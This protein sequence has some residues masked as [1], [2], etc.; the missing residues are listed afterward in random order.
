MRGAVGERCKRE[1]KRM[2]GDGGAI[3]TGMQPGVPD[4]VPPTKRE[5]QMGWWAQ[6]QAVVE[7]CN[8]WRLA[9]VVP[10]ALP[11]LGFETPWVSCASFSRLLVKDQIGD[12]DEPSDPVPKAERTFCLIGEFTVLLV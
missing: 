4:V 1:E 2:G 7:N 8:F 6:T 12:G 3:S 10:P 9:S 11:A 5:R